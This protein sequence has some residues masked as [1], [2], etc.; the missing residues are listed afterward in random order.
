[1]GIVD[2]IIL[3]IILAFAII[4]FKR[5]VFQSLVAVVGFLAVIYIAYL[6]KNI[7]GDFLVLNSP[8]TKY[9][10]IP[11]G[12]YVLNIV[13]YE[14]IGFIAMLIVLGI[15]YEILLVVS[16]VLEKL[17]KITI[18]LGI[19]SKI[20]G[21]ILGALEGFVIVY[22]ILFALRQPF[23]RVNL[24]ENS[25]FA[26]P[27]LKDTPL[28]SNVAESTFEIINEIDETIKT[29]DG[30]DFDLELTDLILKRKITSP[31]V[32]QKLIDKKKLSVPGVQ[33]IVNKY[34]GESSE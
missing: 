13:T 25:K 23:I 20:L 11:G 33:D 14:A 8:F 34:Q 12:S 2:I 24:L 6:L 32:I 3:V 26:E 30:T 16:G 31:D 9:T 29:D 5:G 4:G 19:P 7:L 28:L 15:I 18:I 10:F 27:I 17:L 21:L 22:F 1:M